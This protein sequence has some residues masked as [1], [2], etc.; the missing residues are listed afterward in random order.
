MTTL[1]SP[2]KSDYL[3][4]M[5]FSSLHSESIEW[6]S[7]IEFCNTELAFLEKL[8][9][10]AFLRVN[11]VNKLQELNA[12]ERK[13]KELKTQSLKKLYNE[14]IIHERNLASFDENMFSMNEQSLRDE[15]HKQ[16][17]GVADFMATFKSF[18]KAVF[19]LVEEQI[20]QSDK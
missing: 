9:N 12:L 18:K 2:A 15:H 20:R 13:G 10:K 14:V 16:K 6:L 5:D 1:L 17:S 3:L 19:E 11:N 7:E 4:E 8:M